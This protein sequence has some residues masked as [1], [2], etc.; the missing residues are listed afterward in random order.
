MR[1]KVKPTP[2]KTRLLRFNEVIER[3]G[4]SRSAIYVL[5]NKGEFPTPVRL[6]AKSVAFVE[7]EIEAWIEA[8]LADRVDWAEYV[9]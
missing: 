5:V 6:G 8:R 1:L 7:S 4:K 3:T 2:P 9:V